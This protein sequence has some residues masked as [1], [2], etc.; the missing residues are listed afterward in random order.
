MAKFS[1]FVI[2]FAVVMLLIASASAQDMV[3][4]Y[5]GNCVC[6]N[7]YNAVCG[8]DGRTYKNQCELDCAKRNKPA[9]RKRHD[10]RCIAGAQQQ[11]PS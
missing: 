8:N 6:P 1:T 2:A 3:G 4:R 10:G 7:N 11:I 9:L 5:P